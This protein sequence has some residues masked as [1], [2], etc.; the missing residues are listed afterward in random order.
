MERALII[1]SIILS[2]FASEAANKIEGNVVYADSIPVELDDITAFANDSIS[3]TL[4]EIV[5]KAPLVRREADRIV[6]NV[7][8]NPLSADK[9]ARE[10]LKTAPGVWATDETLSIYGQ[11]GA[12]VYIDDRNVNMSGR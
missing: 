12:T 7:A 2:S 8:A 4:Q 11:G 10:L 3:A 6:L 1:L 9:D 5:V